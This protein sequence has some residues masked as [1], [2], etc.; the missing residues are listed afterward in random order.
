MMAMERPARVQWFTEL[1]NRLGVRLDPALNLL[2]EVKIEESQFQGMRAATLRYIR[3]CLGNPVDVT[4]EQALL[5]M[6]GNKLA[7]R[8]PNGVLFP[9]REFQV[10]FNHLH[11]V[12]AAWLRGAGADDLF[13]Q[14]C[15]PIVV[16]LVKGE[17]DLKEE[18]RPY[19]STKLHS[20]IWT[21][22]PSDFIGIRIPVL[23][24]LK[25]TSIAFYHPPD[26]FEERYQRLLTDYDEGKE[27]EVRS[28]KYPATLRHGHAYFVDG[29]L[30]HRTVK[31]GG[32][33][34]VTIQIELRRPTPDVERREIERLCALGR[35][36]HYID[37]D[38]WYQYGTV[39]FMR[40]KDT[41]ADT[42]RET[43]SKRPAEEPTYEVV[44]S[45]S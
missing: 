4:S 7:N 18:S 21:G 6:A 39:K 2:A 38:E 17:R 44:A 9:K 8:T 41:Y 37:R 24:D 1:S 45:L 3:A 40:F 20:D 5:E 22:E 28:V 12:M 31:N 42:L 34:R 19:S 32:V 13:Y 15:C 11:K 16:R 23:G 30:L 43:F 29:T 26:D 35:L 14:I 33:A 27:L 25:Q 10:E 36:S